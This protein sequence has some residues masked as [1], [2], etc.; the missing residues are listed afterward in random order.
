M[1]W[2]MYGD[3]V[4]RMAIDPE[5]GAAVGQP[6]HGVGRNG[7]LARDHQYISAVAVIGERERAADWYEAMGR[8]HAELPS[9]ERW[10]RIMEARDRGECPEGSYH[11]AR[12]FK[13]LSP[14]AVPLPEVFFGG[15]GDR[16]FEPNDE[17]TA[18]VEVRGPLAR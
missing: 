11:Y 13:T 4:V 7:R 8:K 2:A 17:G 1:V 3:P 15:D 9:E 18:Y 5:A 6:E 16:V 12:V 14:T 10:D